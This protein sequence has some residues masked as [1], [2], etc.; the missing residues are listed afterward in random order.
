MLPLLAVIIPILPL[1]A[2]RQF[3]FQPF[4]IP[5]GGMQPTLMGKR[6]SADGGTIDG[7][8][9]IVTK[10]NYRMHGPK[11]G[12][13]VVFKTTGIDKIQRDPFR[14][15]DNEFYVKRLVGFPGEKVSIR[16]PYVYINGQKLLK[17]E[18]FEI[19]SSGHNGFEGFMSGGAFGS[20]NKEIELGAGEYYVLGDNVRNSLDSRYYG[21][22]KQKSFV[23]KVGWIFW[24][25][26][27]RGAPE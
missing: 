17:P 18:I 12:D 13:L 24:P 27:R 15:P 11:R 14:I 10:W 19:I 2:V 5:T 21:P 7:D 1:V 22:I 3:L 4:A 26:E 8:H 23:G 16:P 20:D 25:P 6:K 9:I